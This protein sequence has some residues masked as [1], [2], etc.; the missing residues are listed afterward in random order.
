MKNGVFNNG[1]IVFFSLG[2]EVEDI[3]FIVKISNNNGDGVFDI[4]DGACKIVEKE[5]NL[6]PP[7][8]ND[9]PVDDIDIEDIDSPLIEME[10]APG[11]NPSWMSFDSYLKHINFDYG[12]MG[13]PFINVNECENVRPINSDE[14]DI[15]LTYK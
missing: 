1:S 4:V 10:Q 14:F 12:S 13:E 3:D 6:D 9:M 8:P 11:S 7:D 5:I 15:Y 2:N